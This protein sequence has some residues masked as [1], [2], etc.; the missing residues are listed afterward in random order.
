M[1]APDIHTLVAN[2]IAALTTVGVGVSPVEW[3][4]VCNRVQMLQVDADDIPRTVTPDD[5][6]GAAAILI[7][8][9]ATTPYWLEKVGEKVLTYPYTRSDTDVLDVPTS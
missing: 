4:Q 2:V 5:V 8:G 7:A 1:A 3:E 6:D 9:G